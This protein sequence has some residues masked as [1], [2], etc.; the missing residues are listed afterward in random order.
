MSRFVELLFWIIELF[1][2]RSG[3]PVLQAFRRA[4]RALILCM[5]GQ[6][7]FLLL[8][9]TFSPDGAVNLGTVSGLADY[10]KYLVANAFAFVALAFIVGMVWS[11]GRCLHIYFKPEQ[12]IR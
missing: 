2:V 11:A 3:D 1:E 6:A 7:L 12:Y 5:I 9:Y 8:A 10:I 4:R